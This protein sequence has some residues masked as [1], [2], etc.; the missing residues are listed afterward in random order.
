MLAHTALQAVEWALLEVLHQPPRA[1]RG[2][3]DS[4]TPGVRTRLSNRC[5]CK[6]NPTPPHGRHHCREQGP[7]HGEGTHRTIS[8]GIR[9]RGCHADGYGATK[10]RHHL[11]VA[12]QQNLGT[13]VKHV[14][15]NSMI[16]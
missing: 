7:R 8:T 11:P 16:T 15:E 1:Y 3:R 9:R 6:H 2:S 13:V 14:K 10:A 12:R 5:W 4:G